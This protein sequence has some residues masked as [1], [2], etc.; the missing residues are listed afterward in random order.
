MKNIG[1]TQYLRV[2]GCRFIADF[3]GSVDLDLEQS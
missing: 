2:I 3:S 1:V